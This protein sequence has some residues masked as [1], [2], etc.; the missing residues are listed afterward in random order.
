MVL[1]QY[2]SVP[3]ELARKFDNEE[4]VGLRNTSTEHEDSIN[5]HAI[6]EYGPGWVR[7]CLYLLTF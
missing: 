3:M 1:G 7:A 4:H 5:K 2:M 6:Y